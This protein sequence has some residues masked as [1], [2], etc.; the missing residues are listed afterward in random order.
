[1]EITNLFSTPISI[2][3][4][5]E[6]EKNTI[7]G[8][9]EKYINEL[10]FKTVNVDGKNCKYFNIP[11]RTSEYLLD[12][13]LSNT[14]Q[15]LLKKLDGYIYSVREKTLEELKLKV[16]RNYCWLTKSFTN[17]YFTA[18]HHSHLGISG[19]YYYDVS[20]NCG[21]LYFKSVDKF[22]EISPLYE[23]PDIY[24]IQPRNGRMVMFP[25]WLEHGTNPNNSLDNRISLVFDFYIEKC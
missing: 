4:L 19:V 3:D 5:D 6:K 8:E 11:E 12:D 1:M 25:G 20:D 13:Y 17:N 15:L 18:H 2:I 9:I 21:S 23:R 7:N 24:E 22:P 14:K 10:Q 16:T